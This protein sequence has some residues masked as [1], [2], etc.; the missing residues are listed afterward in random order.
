MEFYAIVFLILFSLILGL[1]YLGYWIPKKYGNKKLGKIISGILAI[2]FCIL[3]LSIIFEDKLFF[4]SDAIS[5]LANQN[6][7]LVDDF[8]IINNESGGI[9]DYYHKFELEISDN[10][11]RRLIHKI[12]SEVDYREEFENRVYLPELAKNRYEGDT[13]YANY[14]NKWAFK[15]EMYYPNGK[16]YTPTY[17]IISI[18]KHERKLTFEE[19]LD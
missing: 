1:I 4:K 10:D 16:G 3:I 7:E 6:I 5:L 2:G 19:I 9:R 8:K 17:R 12:E 18:S 11:K 15:K 13:I 14:Q